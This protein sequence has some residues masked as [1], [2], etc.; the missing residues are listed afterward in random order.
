MNRI[1]IS[2]LSL[3][4][5]PGLAGCNDS[6]PAPDA[7]TFASLPEH[8]DEP[9]GEVGTTVE[10][11]VDAILIKD[12]TITARPGG[13]DVQLQKDVLEVRAAAANALRVHF[14]PEGKASAPTQVIDPNLKMDAAFKLDPGADDETMRLN[15]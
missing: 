6:K 10:P 8:K 3:M 9:G 13:F 4:L 11:P 2:I 7:S 14:L 1:Q 15:T 12:G 5:L